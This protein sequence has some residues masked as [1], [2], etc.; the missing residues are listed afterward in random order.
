MRAQSSTVRR[1]RSR[2]RRP[3]ALPVRI[4]EAPVPRRALRTRHDHR[5]VAAALRLLQAPEGLKP[6]TLHF[7][8][9][10][11]LESWTL[12]QIQEW[13]DTLPKDV[14]AALRFGP[15]PESDLLDIHHCGV[16]DAFRPYEHDATWEMYYLA[17]WHSLY[18][19]EEEWYLRCI[20]IYTC[21]GWTS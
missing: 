16:C 21:A 8:I 4:L 1:L 14:L 5:P 19:H 6:V 9:G 12:A 18:E 13:V 2:G 11:D 3:P 15:M 17:E 10:P 20:L 7:D